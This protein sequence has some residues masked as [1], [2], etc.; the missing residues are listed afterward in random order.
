MTT[1]TSDHSSGHHIPDPSPDVQ[2]RFLPR[3]P[4]L[5]VLR[6]I[7]VLAALFVSVWVFGGFS[8]NQQTG[9]LLTSKGFDYRLFGT[10]DLLLQG[11]M[12]ALIALV[13]GAAM[14][15][16]LSK[17][18]QKGTLPKS[19]LFIRR[20]MWLMAFGII[21]GVLLL[22]T[23]DILF[24][25]GIMGILLFP[26]PRFSNKA[27]LIATLFITLVYCG[28]NYWS[29]ADDRSAYQ[30][31]LTVVAAE[32]KISKDSAAAAQKN[33]AFK[34]DTLTKKQKKEKSAWEG[35]VSG[36]KYD[37]KKDDENNKAM[38]ARSYGKVYNHLLQKTQAREAQWT[39]TVGIWDLSAMILLG[40]VLFRIGFFTDRFSARQHLLF[41]L[42]GVTAGLLLGWYRLHYNQ[43]AL[44]DYT[45]YV[46]GHRTPYHLFFPF[47]RTFLAIGYASLVIC[48]LHSGFIKGIF[49]ALSRVGQM[50]LSNYILQTIL[51]TLF[52]TGVGMGYFGRLTQ[53]QLYF[54]V[55][56]I[57]LIEIVFSVIWLRVYTLGPLEWL[58]RCL[59]NWKWLP[60]KIKKPETKATPIPIFS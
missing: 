54:I 15:L 39:Y 18:T 31:Y 40:M 41:A 25:L 56:E 9:L 23:N 21:N 8:E 43:V 26:F 28:K 6:G 5:D 35:I 33:I 34:K 7:A 58:W 37:P 32:K 51:C 14:I 20:Q 53:L 38:R 11:K 57:C 36:M 13:F 29:Y 60:N 46:G 49:R 24:H 45:K 42:A 4:S 27:L 3:I 16:F 1:T 22:W 52:F 17:D 48:M 55:L 2:V 10:V 47:E 59:A 44:H 12:R 50:A 30:K 19:D